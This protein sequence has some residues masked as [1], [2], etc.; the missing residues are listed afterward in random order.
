MP[1]QVAVVDART[2]AE[3]PHGVPKPWLNERIH[4]HGRSP[5]SLLYGDVQV[6]GVLDARVADLL[7]RLGPGLGPEAEDRARRHSG[8]IPSRSPG[9]TSV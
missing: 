5:A 9:S 3:L 4:H 8:R 7:E 1:Q 6:I 2:P